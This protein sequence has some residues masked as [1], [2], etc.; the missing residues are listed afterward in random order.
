MVTKIKNI[1][2]FLAT[3]F[4][5]ILFVFTLVKI[6]NL[7]GLKWLYFGLLCIIDHYFFYF[8]NW[9]PWKPKKKREKRKKNKL[10]EWIES[11][12]FAIIAATL[13]HVFLIQPYVIPTSSLEGTLIRGDFLFVSKFHYGSNVPNTPLFLPFMHNKLPFTKNTPSYLDWIQLGYNRLPGFQKIKRNDIV[14]FNWPTDNIMWECEEWNKDETECLGKWI[15]NDMPFDKKTNYVKRCTAIAG[16]TLEIKDGNLIVNSEIQNIPNDTV[17]GTIQ[18]AYW[19]HFEE[20]NYIKYLKPIGKQ[21][22]QN[23]IEKAFQNNYN[24]EVTLISPPESGWKYSYLKDMIVQ[25]TKEEVEN[26]VKNER[27]KGYKAKISV[28]RIT[29]ELIDTTKKFPFSKFNPRINYNYNHNTYTDILTKKTSSLFPYDLKH[30]WD[31][32]NYGPIYIPKKGDQIVLNDS[33]LKIYKDVIENYESYKLKESDTVYTFQMDYYWMMGDNRH[34]SQDSRAWGFVP[35]DH[36]VG[37]PIFLWL[38]VDLGA[39]KIYNKIRWKRMFSTIHGNGNSR[40]YLPHFIIFMIIIYF[41]KKIYNQISKFK[42]K[43]S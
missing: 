12:F 17:R 25:G 36:V 23:K 43:E 10:L 37:K 13:I 3:S 11:I 33:T 1:T 14:V 34:N 8:I 39:D 15:E 35:E 6:T 26:L 16:D 19:I 22:D 7:Q 27:K 29:Q 2:L 5:F 28:K 18:H 42:K 32:D 40:W 4:L 30:N 31:F 9:T 20:K 38:S 41:R 24:V 21:I